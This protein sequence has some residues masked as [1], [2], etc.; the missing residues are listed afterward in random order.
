MSD[1]HSFSDAEVQ[2]LL[3]LARRTHAIYVAMMQD[4]ADE[5]DALTDELARREALS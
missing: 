3:A 2:D 5:I 4:K 1:L